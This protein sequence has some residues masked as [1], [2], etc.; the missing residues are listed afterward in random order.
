MSGK[1]MRC[2]SVDILMLVVHEVAPLY[3]YAACLNSAIKGFCLRLGDT[4]LKGEDLSVEV[5]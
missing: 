4:L 5:S 3:A 1:S 2:R